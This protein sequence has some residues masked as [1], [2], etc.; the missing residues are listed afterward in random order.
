M[1]NP[2]LQNLSGSGVNMK[3]T[4]WSD[5]TREVSRNVDEHSIEQTPVVV[6]VTGVPSKNIKGSY[7]S[8]QRIPPKSTSTWTFLI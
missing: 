6:V 8:H 5:S 1:R 4:L 2:T 3:I 7:L